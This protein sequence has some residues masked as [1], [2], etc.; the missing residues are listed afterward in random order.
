MPIL[1]QRSAVLEIGGDR[2]THVDRYRQDADMPSLA[3]HPQMAS[4][5]VAVVQLQRDDLV[6]AQ[7]QASE[8][9]QDRAVTKTVRSAQIAAVD[10][11]LRML[12]RNRLRELGGGCP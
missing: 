4:I 2:L 10:G 3:V 6:S 1:A 12:R 8:N 11:E 9:Q 5:P 7:P